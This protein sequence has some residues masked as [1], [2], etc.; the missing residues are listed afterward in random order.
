MN[1]VY[2]FNQFSI[3]SAIVGETLPIEYAQK[4]KG[5]QPI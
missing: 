3:N 1:K 2:L 4:I 5:I